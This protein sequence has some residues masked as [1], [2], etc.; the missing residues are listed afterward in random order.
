MNICVIV[1]PSDG[2][3]KLSEI[4]KGFV[5]GFSSNGHNVTVIS[6]LHDSDK[7]ITIYDYVVV[8]AEPV[9]FFSGKITAKLKTY[10]SGAG[11]VSGKRASVFIS[12]GLRKNKAL[13]NLMHTVESEGVILKSGDII[14][15]R[16]DAK[17][18]AMHLNIERNI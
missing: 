5:D 4:A 12:G 8:L 11:A 18:I 10:L 14:K 7:R 16:E 15:N 3:D 1:A 2:K 6:V 9:S 13:Q 17:V